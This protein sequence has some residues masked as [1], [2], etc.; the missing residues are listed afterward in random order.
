[1]K[2]LTGAFLISAMLAL[3]GCGGGGGGDTAGAAPQSD[4][5]TLAAKMINEATSEDCPT[6]EH[7]TPWPVE[8]LAAVPEEEL[9][10]DL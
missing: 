7:C 5:V 3:V 9:P 8:S 2:R 4:V 1:M 10:A 6:E